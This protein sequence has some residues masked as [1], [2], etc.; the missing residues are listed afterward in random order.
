VP[1]VGKKSAPGPLEADVPF[2][3]AVKKLE[4]IVDAMESGDLPLETLL[5]RFEDGTRLVKLCQA[6]LEQ[7]E[8]Q[9]QKL[10]KDSAGQ[11][12]AKPLDKGSSLAR[13]E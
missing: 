13:N 8:L 11:I 9:I 3:E 5:Q 7:A 2:E 6:R 12:T 1:D 4:S 10:E